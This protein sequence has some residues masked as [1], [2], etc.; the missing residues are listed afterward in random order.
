[1]FKINFEN[2]AEK[3]NR[4]KNKMASMSSEY[5]HLAVKKQQMLIL[6]PLEINST[7]MVQNEENKDLIL[8]EKG[9]KLQ[10]LMMTIK[11]SMINGNFMFNHPMPMLRYYVA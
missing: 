5:D 3:R 4:H 2:I 11:Q 10:V 9:N 7:P 8:E 1:M 6:S